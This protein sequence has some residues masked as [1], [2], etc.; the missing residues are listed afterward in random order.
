MQGSEGGSVCDEDVCVTV[1]A[2]VWPFR[3]VTE[4]KTGRELSKKHQYF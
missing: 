4:Q 2:N 3:P 1:V